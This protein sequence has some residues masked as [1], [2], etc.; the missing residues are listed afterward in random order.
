MSASRG[1]YTPKKP[2]SS[3]FDFMATALR[4]HLH[5]NFPSSSKTILGVINTAFKQLKSSFMQSLKGVAASDTPSHVTPSHGSTASR[6]PSSRVLPTPVQFPSLENYVTQSQDTPEPAD[7]NADTIDQPHRMDQQYVPE[8]CTNQAPQRI[9]FE[10]LV[11]LRHNDEFLL[12]IPPSTRKDPKPFVKACADTMDKMRNIILYDHMKNLTV[13]ACN[14]YFESE[15]KTRAVGRNGRDGHEFHVRVLA[16]PERSLLEMDPIPKSEMNHLLLP[17]TGVGLTIQLIGYSLTAKTLLKFYD[18]ALLQLYI[19]RSPGE[20]IYKDVKLRQSK[21]EELVAKDLSKLLLETKGGATAYISILMQHY[22]AR[23]STKAVKEQKTELSKSI[24]LEYRAEDEIVEK[25][26]LDASG[27]K[28]NAFADEV[29]R[30]YL[31][32][33]RGSLGFN[34]VCKYLLSDDVNCHFYNK[35]R[36]E[37]PYIHEAL[38]SVVSTKYFVE[39]QPKHESVPDNPLLKKQ[40]QI[41]FLFYG[42]IRSRSQLL[43]RHWAIVEPLGYF[44]KGHQ[45]PGN[46]SMAGMFSSS[47]PVSFDK[48]DDIYNGE[49]GDFMSRLEFEPVLFGAFDNYQRMIQKKDQTAHKSAITQKGTAYYAK[50]NIPIHIPKGSAIESPSGI[51]FKVLTCSKH[52]EKLI[53]TGEIYHVK[54]KSCE[55]EKELITSGIIMPR[56]GWD[57]L[58][59]PGFIER[60]SLKYHKQVIPRSWEDKQIHLH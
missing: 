49:V 56:N 17:Q 44:Y 40:N 11:R 3:G 32:A 35:M 18:L 15:L 38:Y 6:P 8:S 24:S 34:Q 58:W 51:R 1:S 16:Y 60:P 29:D 36:K 12:C 39:K 57:V 27:A 2:P 55:S 53:I 31:T 47:L 4:D 28:I 22:Q 52:A 41:L 26:H 20:Q 23:Q 54:A 10:D 50:A 42:L 30:V 5:S 37:F 59:M 43:M 45:Q 7:D 21:N 46:K 14:K 48:L 19:R 9:E 33:M 13:A 25:L